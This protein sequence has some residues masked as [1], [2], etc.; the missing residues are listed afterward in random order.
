[1]Q[2]QYAHL[3]ATLPELIQQCQDLHLL[4]VAASAKQQST[5]T[6]RLAHDTL[7]PLVR[8]QFD[9][10]DKPGQRARRILDNRAV[11]WV[12]DKIGTPLDEADLAIVEQGTQ[13]TRVLSPTE[14]RLL[15]ASRELSAKLNRTR[16]IIKIAT[17]VGV[18]IIT[19]T[20][21]IAMW[22]RSEAKPKL[23]A[24]RRK[25]QKHRRKRIR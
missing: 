16:L 5:R 8:E 22:Q 9:V 13:G 19:I 23:H 6:T 10:S 11:D 4:T 7:A 12:N 18:A 21:S 20:A 25:P 24:S 17:V 1:L 15:V 14:Q 3:D 2:E